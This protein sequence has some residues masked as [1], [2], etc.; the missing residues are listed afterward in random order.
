M[1]KRLFEFLALLLYLWAPGI[2][3]YQSSI[4]D[5]LIKMIVEQ[6]TQPALSI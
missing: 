4:D 2:F 1:D 3:L 5:G 6:I